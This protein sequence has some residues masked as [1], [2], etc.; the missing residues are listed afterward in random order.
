MNF[1]KV[2]YV[3]VRDVSVFSL[4]G[5]RRVKNKIFARHL[6]AASIN[7]DSNVKIQP[8]H[9][10]VSASTFGDHFHVG[11]DCV[12]DLSGGITVGERVTVSEGAKIY[13]HS[14]PIDGG[15]QDWRLNQVT[16]SPLVIEDDVWI[17]SGAIVLSSVNRIG[18][19]AIVA[20]GSVLR[21]NVDAQTLVAGVPAKVIRKRQLDVRC[22]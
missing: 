13:T 6:N 11:A 4:P 17:G 7:V 2:F 9:A 19:G 18:A 20:A 3:L 21:H 14:H 10:P 12:V 5:F 22:G 1:V 8:L 15:A 16:Y